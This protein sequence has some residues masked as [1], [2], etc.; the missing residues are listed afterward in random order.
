MVLAVT[1][2]GGRL[3][4]DV[5]ANHQ[6]EV[7]AESP[8]TFFFKIRPAQMIFVKSEGRITHLDWVEHGETLR[9]NK[10]K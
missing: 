4:T 9:A 8:S 1:S 10:I 3:F 5:P 7:F 6:T 2:E